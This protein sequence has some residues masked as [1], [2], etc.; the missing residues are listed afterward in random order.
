MSEATELKTAVSR[1]TPPMS[2]GRVLVR[3]AL[4][5]LVLGAGGGAWYWITRS[6]APSQV[7]APATAAAV[8]VVAGA[9]SVRDVPIWLSGIGTVT[10][11]NV[12]DVKVRVDGQLESVA[13]TEGQEVVAGR[14]LA[15][16]DPRPYQATLAQAEANRHKDLAQLANARLEVIRAGKLASAGAGTSQNFDAMKA[17]DAA[18]QAAVAA[19][20]AAIDAARLNLEFT[21]IVSPLDGRVGLREAYPGSIVHASDTTGLVTVTQMAPISVMFTLPQDELA[22]VVQAQRVGDLPVAID[23]RDGSRHIADGRLVFINSTVDPATGQIQLKA[24]FDNADRALWP[25]EFVSAR[26][27]ART[28]R[29]AIVV[30][31]QAVLIGETGPYVY[32]LR[33]DNAVAAQTIKAGQSV[34]GFT[35]ILT[36]LAPGQAVVL[37]G[38]S[39]LRPG[40]H[41]T[42]VPDKPSSKGAAS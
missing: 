36:G 17:Q 32:V 31:A 13:F 10:P 25:G 23:S 14:A 22:A 38:Q 41:I 33:P 11:I 2:A 3:L 8:P 21:R 16:I 1:S 19:D 30:P 34:D 24:A 15:Q 40:S 9:A 37:G 28:D 29:A 7:S 6:H 12:V 27:L 35:E 20:Q 4:A 39:R 18:L 26:V 5:I 42:V